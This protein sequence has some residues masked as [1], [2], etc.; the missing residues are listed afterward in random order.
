[1]SKK[2]IASA[3]IVAGAI[4][5][6]VAMGVS[7][8]PAHAAKLKCFGVSLAKANDCAAG[9]GTTCAG[10]SSVDYQGNA[11]KYVEAESCSDIVIKVEGQADRMG[12]DTALTRDL[13]S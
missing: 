10:T 12:S 3:A 5:S 2:T 1:M 4:S 13:P 9:E 7:V 6:A 11:W 8:Q